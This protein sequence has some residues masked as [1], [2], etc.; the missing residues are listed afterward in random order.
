MYECIIRFDSETANDR[1][2]VILKQGAQAWF[3][4]RKLNFLIV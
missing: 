4:F 1:Q 2:A 3:F